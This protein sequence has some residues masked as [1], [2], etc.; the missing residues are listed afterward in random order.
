MGLGQ[1]SR[2]VLGAPEQGVEHG[3]TSRQV[4]GSPGGVGSALMP[5]PSAHRCSRQARPPAW[6]PSSSSTRATSSSTSGSTRTA[7]ARSC[8]SPGSACPVCTCAPWRRGPE[9][10]PHGEGPVPSG[11][12]DRRATGPAWPPPPVRGQAC[13]ALLSPPPRRQPP[14]AGPLSPALSLLGCAETP[15]MAAAPLPTLPTGAPLLAPDAQAMLAKPQRRRPPSPGPGS[16]C[17]FL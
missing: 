2:E 11:S 13:A 9:P 14:R 7:R 16:L 12:G 1:H 3:P 15:D 6:G 17:L 4:Q 8:R 5:L 10:P